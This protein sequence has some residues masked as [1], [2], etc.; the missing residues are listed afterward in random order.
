MCS[1]SEH[2]KYYDLIG[3]RVYWVG[4]FSALIL[5]HRQVCQREVLNESLHLGDVPLPL[6][7]ARL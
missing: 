6:V 7:Y 3:A 4:R 2:D 1:N 5:I